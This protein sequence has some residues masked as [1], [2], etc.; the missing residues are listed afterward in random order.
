MKRPQ[1]TIHGENILVPV[2]SIPTGESKSSEKYVVG[3][4]ETGHNHVLEAKKG[5]Q[6][7]ITVV[8]EDV[9]I[10]TKTPT[11]LVHK[12]NNDIHQTLTIEPGIYKVVHA[13]EYNPFTKQ[14][15]R[16]FD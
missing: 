9:Y 6:F 16:I 11:K 14:L 1:A 12:K 5:E 3:H 13:V 8:G 10:T 15:Q 2:S 7:D 4:S